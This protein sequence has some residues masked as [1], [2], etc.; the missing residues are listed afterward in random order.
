M[1]SID[2]IEVI[3]KLATFPAFQLQLPVA[4]PS[5]AASTTTVPMPQRLLNLPPSHT[6]SPHLALMRQSK[7]KY[8]NANLTD[9]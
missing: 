2:L 1:I 6:K 4:G 7:Q 8:L 3:L 5:C 9:N